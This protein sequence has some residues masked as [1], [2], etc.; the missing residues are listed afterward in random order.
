MKPIVNKIQT[1]FKREF[2][3]N[4]VGALWVP[5]GISAIAILAVV[6]GLIFGGLHVGAEVGGAVDMR[7]QQGASNDVQII[8]FSTGEI[9]AQSENTLDWVMR[10]AEVENVMLGVLL[11]IVITSQ[12]LALAIGSMYL[13]TA[14]YSDR[15]DRSILFWKS[16]P[17]SETQVVLVKLLF[18]ALIIPV[19]CL[20]VSLFVQLVYAAVVAYF[21]GM[22][23]HYTFWSVF[24]DTPFLEVFWRSLF[25][26][27][28]AAFIWLPVSSWL[29][30]SSAIARRSPLFFAIFVP[31]AIWVME[32]LIFGSRHF[33]DSLEFLL[34][35]SDVD[36]DNYGDAWHQ[37]LMSVLSIS[38]TQAITIIGVSAALLIGS[39]W[40]RNN[41]YEI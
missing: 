5:A 36:F 1:Q 24:L 37:W 12:F 6:I 23:Q 35:L 30:F 3:E 10:G 20:L 21:F 39:I 29:L 13:L 9:R 15:K 18:G 4:K 27:V 28:V 17:I 38:V 25:Y 8:D 32:S 26:L 33:A 7:G 22:S 11:A 2:W 31:V 40:L 19:I 41:R 34:N 14:L 16:L